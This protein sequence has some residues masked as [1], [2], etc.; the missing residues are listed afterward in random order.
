MSI[1]ENEIKD[2]YKIEEGIKEKEKKVKEECEEDKKKIMEI[3]EKKKEESKEEDKK[4]VKQIDIQNYLYDEPFYSDDVRKTYKINNSPI[5]SEI[6]ILKTKNNPPN[7]CYLTAEYSFKNKSIIC[8]GG[9][10]DYCN[11]YNKITEYNIEKNIWEFWKCE[12]QTEMGLELSGHTSNLV[13]IDDEEKIF[14]FGGYD[15]WKNEFTAQSYLIDIKMKNFEK[16]NY[17]NYSLNE[18]PLPRT[19]HTSNYDY[20]NNYI[21]IYGGTDM[22]INN[23][24]EDNFQALWVFHLGKKVWKK[25]DF[26]YK[27]QDGAPRGHSSIL[28]KNKLYIFGGVTLFK[29]YQNYM[30]IIDLINI[31]M[32]K[33]DYNDNKFIKSIIPQPMAFHNAVII[34][35]NKF[36]IHGGLD[37]NYN[38]I[39]SIYIYYVDEMKF[40][41]INIPLIPNLFG[42]KIVSNDDQSRL[43]IIGGMNTFKN[44]GDENLIYKIE[45]DKDSI[46]NKNEGNV[47]YFPMVNILEIKLN[48]REENIE[49]SVKKE[50]KEETKL[51]KKRKWK[52]LFYSNINYNC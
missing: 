24:K 16:I 12:N 6:S 5:I 47:E 7:R 4:K 36:L 42:H 50:I 13:K 19:Y 31:K 51:N 17:N 14:I 46:F 9:S 3:K 30:F 45:E 10:D 37:K 52:K 25:I 32:E 11:Q 15:N 21:Y 18:F 2:I 35:E 20:N 33:V 23:C 43:Y 1:N 26:E 49:S 29:K 44:V 34:D 39:N 48:K 8:I 28:L 40:D 27:P 41:K 38:P 22:N